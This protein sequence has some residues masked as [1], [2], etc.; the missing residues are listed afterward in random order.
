MELLVDIHAV[1]KNGDLRWKIGFHGWQQII[2]PR[3]LKR[4]LGATASL[5]G[6]QNNRHPLEDWQV[7]FCGSS[8]TKMDVAAKTYTKCIKNVLRDGG[9]A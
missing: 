4:L 8:I 1:G 6:A 2:G 9:D 7:L 3:S 5:G